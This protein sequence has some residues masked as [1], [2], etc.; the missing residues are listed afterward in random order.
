MGQILATARQ[1]FVGVATW[2][3]TRARPFINRWRLLPRNTKVMVASGAIVII[4]S[5]SWLSYRAVRGC[6]SKDAVMDRVALVM[7]TLQD[8]AAHHRITI[9]E[10]AD[11]LKRINVAAA[12]YNATND[13]QA[14]CS[15]LN[16]ISSDTAP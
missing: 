15:A 8:D 5:I 4:L 16:E 6:S 1:R 9:T 14:Y 7:A 3:H 11:A 13:A 2:I 10:L 12:E